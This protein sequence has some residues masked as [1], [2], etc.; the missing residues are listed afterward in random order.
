MAKYRFRLSYSD[1]KKLIPIKLDNFD[2]ITEKDKT[3]IKAI[4]EFTTKYEDIND[5]LNDLKSKNLIPQDVSY[6]Y[7]TFNYDKN[8][9]KDL[10]LYAY[11]KTLF[12][13]NDKNILN[14]NY[15]YNYIIENKYNKNFLNDI[16]ELYERKLKYISLNS[17]KRYAKIIKEEKIW[18]LSNS[19]KE[20]MDECLE[21]FI[22]IIL[23]KKNSTVV[24]YKNVRD[25]L[26]YIMGEKPIPTRK[27]KEYDNITITTITKSNEIT[28]ITEPDN[29]T[30][31]EYKKFN[32]N[33]STKKREFEPYIEGN[34]YITDTTDEEIEESLNNYAIQHSL[35]RDNGE[36]E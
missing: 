8:N 33:L 23:K 26:C 10:D 29:V 22:N 2:F 4:D 28:K 5:L 27:V 24:D 9:D 19:D 11:Y 16:I 12:F 13:K 31:E 15:V 7:L 35:K 36:Y 34:D 17:L 18:M 30:L 6:L 3:S 1:G 25:F 20:D 32:K 14:F 21:Y